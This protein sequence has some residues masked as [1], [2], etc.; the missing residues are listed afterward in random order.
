MKL[1]IFKLHLLSWGGW[2]HLKR[3]AIWNIKNPK[4]PILIY[5]W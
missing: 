3:G 1:K 2:T 5:E 4:C